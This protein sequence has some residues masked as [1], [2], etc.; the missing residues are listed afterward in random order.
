MRRFEFADDRSSKFWEIEQ[1]GLDLNLRWG[2]IGT[3]GQGQV[4]SFADE[5]K[6][7]AAIAKLIAEKTGK[8]Y[9]E[10]GAAAVATS[11]PVPAPASAPA[12]FTAPVR[13]PAAAVD[14]LATPPWLAQGEPLAISKKMADVALASRHAP[15]PIPPVDPKQ[16][17]RRLHNSVDIMHAKCDPGVLPACLEASQ[18]LQEQ[19]LDGS[20][21]SDAVLLAVSNNPLFR[22]DKEDEHPFG[23]LMLDAIAAHKGLEYCV[24]VFL[25]MLKLHSGLHLSRMT[26]KRVAVIECSGLL[27]LALHEP[28][29][30]AEIALRRQLSNAPEAVWQAC[31]D[32]IEKALPSTPIL[33]RAALAAQ[34]PERP[35]LSNRLVFELIG[36]PAHSTLPLL[37]MSANEPQL[38]RV[39]GEKMPDFG[40]YFSSPM[41]AASIL[42]EKGVQACTPFSVAVTRDV[43]SEALT[44][45]G[46]PDAIK[47]LVE[48]VA[49]TSAPQYERWYTAITARTALTRLA[50]ALQ[51]WPMAGI[52]GLAELGERPGKVGTVVLSNLTALVNAHAES[53]PRLLPW[54]SPAAQALLQRLH[55][56]VN[57][58]AAEAAREDLPSVLAN[59]PWL[60]PR[61]KAVAPMDLQALPLAPVE[62]WDDVNRE[63]WADVGPWWEKKFEHALKDPAVWVAEL[64]FRSNP[65]WAGDEAR[66]QAMKAIAD[67]DSKALA[68]AWRAHASDSRWSRLAPPMI[69]LLPGDMGVETWNLLSCAVDASTKYM[70]TVLARFG[71]RALPGF[72]ALLRNRF[73]E[74]ADF[75]PRFGS[76]GIAAPMARAAAKLK[77]LQAQGREWL[78]R[79]PEHA[80]CGLIAPALGK[81]GEERDCA[82]SALLYLRSN[83]HESMILEVAA[84]YESTAVA[85]AVRALLDEDPLERVPDK[86]PKLPAFWSPLGWR[87]P[88]LNETCGASAGK[89]IPN[90]V[91]DHVGTMLMLPTVDG[92]YPGIAQLRGACTPESLADFSW[93]CFMAWLNAGGAAKEGWAMSALGWFGTD[94][95]ARKLMPFI[96]A[97]P[98]EGAHARAVAALDVLTAIG[99]EVALMLMNGVAQKAKQKPLQDKAR[100]KIARIAEARGLTAE[101]L[102]D[103][104][105]PDL[106][107]EQDGTM[108]LDFGPRRFLAGFDEALKPFVRDEDGNRLPDLPKPRQSD[109][110]ALA[111]AAVER[112]K[113]LKKDA[114]AIASQQVKRLEW[115]M[116]SRRRWSHA[117]F[118]QFL[119]GH[120]LLRHLV[121]RLVW[122][123]YAVGE[124]GARLLDCFRVAADGSYA[125]SDDDTFTLPEG[126][127]IQVGLPHALE[128]PPQ[129]AAKFAQLFVDYKLVQ[130][131]AQLARDTYSLEAAELAQTQLV[132]WKGRVVTTSSVLG[133]ASK[134][135]QRGESI[136]GGLISSF[137]KP[138]DGGRMIELKFEPGIYAGMVSENPQQS[139][140]V[141]QVGVSTSWGGIQTADN[142]STLDPIATSELIRDIES[143]RA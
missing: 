75:A 113:A 92:V 106:G 130:P 28:F 17:L 139:L 116:C 27:Q 9:V 35:E 12:P 124:D 39:L 131:F 45:I 33:R 61:K 32:K 93:D 4:K 20:L 123:V 100:E 38:L 53:I 46:T 77:K 79:F 21:M 78:L 81:A 121:Q 36:S 76:V 22:S 137:H 104:M 51:Q 83:G 107:L 128:L 55:G 127:H 69:V 8:G 82:K 18:R 111:T 86:I 95:T 141:V 138:V 48:S 102:E 115:A 109:D 6:C 23:E 94:D 56:Q 24:D 85:A 84:R 49:Q 126:E 97:W 63:A 135:W 119:A 101:E 41:L 34:L 31:A 70:E 57:T 16:I 73:D 72:E 44:Q 125:T 88:V 103:R 42:A 142:L 50:A 60:R 136:G 10:T 30:G 143:L 71:L 110:E 62:R 129:A 80:I 59:P 13:A 122:G 120:P 52:A 132:R 140:D 90:D 134:G 47:L 98:P 3:Q 108:V 96:K 11:A 37:L 89:A 43:V 7:A 29:C 40:R 118:R 99:S 66:L 2:R 74:V 1:N 91:V 65:E 26:G 64:G 5:A 19:S 54:V 14:P 87:R 114:R 68:A 117:H 58:A 25:Q 112:F 105:A 133:L 15:K 67:A